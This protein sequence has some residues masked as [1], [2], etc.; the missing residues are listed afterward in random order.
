MMQRK[1][2]LLKESRE[3]ALEEVKALTVYG[4]DNPYERIL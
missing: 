3:R 4:Q 2:D 1:E